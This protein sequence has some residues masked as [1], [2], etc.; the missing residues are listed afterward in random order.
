MSFTRYVGTENCAASRYQEAVENGTDVVI[1]WISPTANAAV[2]LRLDGKPLDPDIKGGVLDFLDLGIFVYLTDEMVGRAQAFDYWTRS[3]PCLL[4]VDDPD[5]WRRSQR[6]LKETLR[7]LSNDLWEFEWLQLDGIPAARSH[8]L[9]LPE[10][11]DAV[12]LFSGGIDSLLGAVRLLDD[13]RKVLLVGHQ[14]EGQAARAQTS[15]ADMLRKLYPGQVRLVQCRVSRS[16]C[17]TPQFTLAP[18]I[19]RSHRPRSFLFL[20]LGVAIAAKCGI[21]HVFMP[22]N[23]FMALNV[24]LQK[25][26]AGALS[27]RTAHPSFMLKFAQLAQEIAGF[28]GCIRNP[29]LVQSK[30]DMLRNIPTA[31]RPL[32]LRS[33]SCARPSQYNDRSVRHCGYC[34]PCIHRRIALMEADL[35]SAKQYAFDVLKDFPSLDH[36]KQQDFRAVVRFAR[37]VTQASTAQLQTAIL[38]HGH[39]PADVGGTIGVDATTSY[40]PWIEMLRRWANDFVSKVRDKGSAS[41]RRALMLARTQRAKR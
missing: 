3:I 30:T 16:L 20:A 12:C 33:V 36:N 14:A 1:D 8:R 29:Y 18:K 26:R 27:T 23:G 7:I 6:L 5:K 19:E 40:D 13:K 25:S 17:C 39:F 31:L 9:H 15:L 35:D 10:N 21:A 32:I 38:S 34:V 28:T 41:T 22:E 11:C 37:W 2:A 4:P 24:P